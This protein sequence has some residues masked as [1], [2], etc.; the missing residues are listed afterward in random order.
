MMLSNWA[1]YLY[2]VIHILP[3][4]LDFSEKFKPKQLQKEFIICQPIPYTD[5]PPFVVFCFLIN[6]IGTF[7]VSSQTSAHNSV[8]SKCSLDKCLS[9]LFFSL[10][11]HFIQ[12]PI[13]TDFFYTVFQIPSLSNHLDPLSFSLHVSI[14]LLYS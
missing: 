7:L 4:I 8:F 9:E 3:F 11:L 10:T 13:C 12:N 5:H 1:F 2:L 14:I 6:F